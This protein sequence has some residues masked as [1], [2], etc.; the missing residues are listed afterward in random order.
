MV[1]FLHR[2]LIHGILLKYTSEGDDA[3]YVKKYLVDDMKSLARFTSYKNKT[4]N[5]QKHSGLY[6]Q[7]QYFVNRN[8]L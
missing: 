6:Y 2:C 7:E 8:T 1:V 5:V 3:L 4:E